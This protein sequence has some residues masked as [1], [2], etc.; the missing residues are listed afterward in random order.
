[1][2]RRRRGGGDSVKLH[3]IHTPDSH[4]IRAEW[5]VAGAAIAATRTASP[6]PDT[7]LRQRRQEDHAICAVAAEGS[8]TIADAIAEAAAIAG[9]IG[10]FRGKRRAVTAR[11][12]SLK[13]GHRWHGH[14]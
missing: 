11:Q 1:M 13:N 14:G 7:V 2:G 9:V 12:S 4:P 3:L 5:V 6:A 10:P 8:H